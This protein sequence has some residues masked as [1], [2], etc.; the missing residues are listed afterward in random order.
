M[1]HFEKWVTSENGHNDIHHFENWSDRFQSASFVEMTIFSKWFI[2]RSVSFPKWPIFWIGSFFQ[3]A[4]FLEIYTFPKRP[5]SRSD[6]FFE[7][8]HARNSFFTDIKVLLPETAF[9]ASLND[10]VV[11]FLFQSWYRSA[12]FNIQPKFVKVRISKLMSFFN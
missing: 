9:S 11:I 4:P 6:L 2:F 8:R 10:T 7:A 3:S 12:E 5:I 1:G